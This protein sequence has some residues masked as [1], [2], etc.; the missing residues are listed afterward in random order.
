MSQISARAIVIGGSAGSV[1]AL[2]TILSALSAEFS[3]PIIA[4]VH[5][6]P[7]SKS[8]LAEILQ[9]KCLLIIEE[10]EDKVPALP[11]HVYI[12]PPNY[13]V[14]PEKDGILSLSAEEEVL[15]SRPSIDVLF[16]TAAD[17]YNSELIGVLVTGANED[18]A[19]GL[20]CIVDAGGMAII[21]DP[22]TA[23]APM[24]PR[25]AQKICPQAPLMT[26]KQI[27]EFLARNVT[28]C[29]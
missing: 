19:K 17:A 21:Q 28:S 29:R 6:P 9:P 13:H 25:A 27:G 15:F 14:L 23:Y 5:I 20:R 18:G 7:D 22:A 26:L 1:D 10:I 24:M 16:E 12:A 2:T 11:G 4:V 3:V 8:L